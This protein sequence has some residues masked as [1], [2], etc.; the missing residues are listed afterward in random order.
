MFDTFGEIHIEHIDCSPADG[1]TAHQ[2]RTVP[3]EVFVPT[4]RRG[5][6]KRVNFPVSGSMPAML[7]PL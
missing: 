7:G 6:N 5:L 4:S 1:S 3:C 2:L